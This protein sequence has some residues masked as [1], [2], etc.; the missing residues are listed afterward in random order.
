MEKKD[1]A[2]MNKNAIAYEA[3][4][5][6]RLND[7]ISGHGMCAS[8]SGDATAGGCRNTGNGATGCISGNG[9]V[10]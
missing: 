5:A 10:G 3:P 9:P 8:G 1:T 2:H 7:A 6:M 4:M